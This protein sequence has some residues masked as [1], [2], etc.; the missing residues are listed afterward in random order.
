MVGCYAWFATAVSSFGGVFSKAAA[1]LPND[2]N[3]QDTLPLGAVFA[4]SDT[5]ESAQPAKASAP[6]LPQGH[7]SHCHLPIENDTR[8]RDILSLSAVTPSNNTVE[9]SPPADVSERPFLQRPGPQISF[10]AGSHNTTA[11]GNNFNI[12]STTPTEAGIE[13]LS[14]AIYQEATH[15]SSARYPPPKCHPQTRT[16]IVEFFVNWVKTESPPEQVYWLNAPFGHGKSAIMQTIIDHLI[17]H[18][19]RDCVA[20]SFFFGRGKH[21]RDRIDYLLPSIAYQMAINLPGMREIVNRAMLAEPALPSKSIDVQLACLIINPLL[22]WASGPYFHH[23]PSVFI[24]GLDECDTFDAQLAVLDLITKSLLEHHV[25]LRFVVASRPEPHIRNHFQQVRLSSISK[26]YEVPNDDAEM[27]IYVKSRS[28]E[29]FE[30]RSRIMEEAGVQKPW[31]SADEINDLVRRASGQ[32]VFLDTIIRFVDTHR[33]SPADRLNIVLRRLN[34]PSVFM[35]MDIIYRLVLEQCPDEY[36]PLVRIIID[37]VVFCRKSGFYAPVTVGC[38]AEISQYSTLQL[39]LAIESVAA[40]IKLEQYADHIYV[41]DGTRSIVYDVTPSFHHLSFYEFLTDKDRSGDFFHGPEVSIKRWEGCIQE[42]FKKSLAAEIFPTKLL[43]YK[44]LVHTLSN[45]DYHHTWTTSAEL[46][47][48]L[49]QGQLTAQWGT[50]SFPGWYRNVHLLAEAFAGVPWLDDWTTRVNW[51]RGDLD[52]PFTFDLHGQCLQIWKGVADRA[53]AEMDRRLANALLDSVP[54]A[55][56]P[57]RSL[58]ISELATTAGMDAEEC[59]QMLMQYPFILQQ[60]LENISDHV[61]LC[62]QSYVRFDDQ[63]KITYISQ[64][65]RQFYNSIQ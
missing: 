57:R 65:R 9:L 50:K 58:P 19:H 3:H 41:A 53:F 22:E 27:I 56:S 52:T 32:Y 60:P 23:S 31:P 46:Q 34:D 21:G 12:N 35:K 24:D 28:D 16:E 48:L 59:L 15:D 25:P 39:D 30:K 42:A 47:T 10:F 45:D 33:F 37:T 2:T 61:D 29:I 49:L 4:S 11:I 18:G 6:P 7:H 44:V 17:E 14:K 36:R 43:S 26:P 51:R 63:G 64:I 40:V 8:H 55:Y 1:H 54:P 38:I 20:G 13:K 62:D 5:V